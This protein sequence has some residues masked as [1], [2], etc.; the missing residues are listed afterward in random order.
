MLRYNTDMWEEKNQQLVR[1]FKFADFKTALDF[2]NKVSELAEVA[3]HHPDI[4]LGWGRVQVSL[5]THSEHAVT[6]KDR[7]LAGE[8]DQL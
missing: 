8:I 2:V 4:E 6:E 1:E 3:N 5:T 7:Q